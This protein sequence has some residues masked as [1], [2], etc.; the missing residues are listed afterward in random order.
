LK[1]IVC[2]VVLVISAV[3]RSVSLLVGLIRIDG[4]ISTVYI[5]WDYT[6]KLV[7]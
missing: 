7:K 1:Y 4:M 5:I 3:I 6:G 2:I